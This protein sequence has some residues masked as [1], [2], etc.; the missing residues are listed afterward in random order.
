MRSLGVVVA[1][2]CLDDDLCLGEA[3]EDLT[4]EQFVAQL[5]VEALAVAVL[6]RAA[7][8]DERSLRTDGDNPLPHRFGVTARLL[9]PVEAKP[10]DVR[11]VFSD[12]VNDV[13]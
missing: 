13:S 1:S 3:I 4:V 5:R 10:R 7:R 8:L 2:P 9:P 12:D 6:P 11:H